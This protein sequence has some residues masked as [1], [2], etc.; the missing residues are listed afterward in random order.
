MTILFEGIDVSG[1]IITAAC[2]TIHTLVQEILL[3][4]LSNILAIG[5]AMD[6]SVLL[7]FNYVL[8]KQSAIDIVSNSN[9]PIKVVV[10]TDILLEI[11]N[12]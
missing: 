4:F 6:P 9:I 2:I 8:T 3:N 7:L 11:R 1:V 5:W 10:V 12:N